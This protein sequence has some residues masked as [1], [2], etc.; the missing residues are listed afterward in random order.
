MESVI[1]ELLFLA[2]FYGLSGYMAAYSWNIMW[3]DCI[4]LFPLV[5]L[6]LERLIH[7]DKCFLY[8]ITLGLCIL[9]N[10]YISIMICIFLVI[11]FLVQLLLASCHGVQYL[12]KIGEFA[13]YSLL[14]GGLAAIVLLPEIYALQTTAS[15]SISFPQTI[16]SYF[17]IFDMIAR[18]LVDVDVHIGL[19]H[20]PNIYCGVAILF[21]IPLYILNRRVNFY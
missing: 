3:L 7:Q 5:I 13:L 12:K 18:H 20:W 2:F 8:C 4:L 1:L 17:S 9:S 14:A 21:L 6:G 15:S 16:V 10:Y 19:D 11:Y